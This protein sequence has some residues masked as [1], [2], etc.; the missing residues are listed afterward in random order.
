MPWECK[1][2]SAAAINDDVSACPECGVSKAS[3]T[4]IPDQTRQLT[5]TRRR[6]VQ[7][8]RSEDPGEPLEPE[9][10]YEGLALA[11]AESAP[12]IPKQKAQE[13]HEA[14]QRPAPGQLLFVRLFPREHT[15]HTVK[16]TVLYDMAEPV[17]VELPREEEAILR[18]DGS[19]DVPLLCVYGPDALPE[20]VSFA[21]IEIVDVS[22]ETPT[23]HASTL[24]VAALAKKRSDLPLSGLKTVLRFKCARLNF[25]TD[26]AIVRPVGLA[27]L[28]GVLKQVQADPERKLLIAGHTDTEASDAYNQALS[29]A[30]AKNVLD[31]LTGDAEAWVEDASR[32]NNSLN[33]DVRETLQWAARYWNFDCDPGTPH[34]GSLDGAAR[35][36][37]EQFK[38]AFNERFSQDHLSGGDLSGEPDQQFWRRVLNLYG[39]ALIDNLELEDGA[40]LQTLCDTIQWADESHGSIGCGEEQL[41]VET[42]D[43]VDEEANRR[44]DFLFFHPDEVPEPVGEDGRYLAAV[45]DTARFTIE[46]LPCPDPDIFGRVPPNVVF[47]IDVSGSMRP[48]GASQGRPAQ[49][50]RIGFAKRKL[51]QVIEDLREGDHF[52]VIAYSTETQMLWES[53]GA[54][55]LKVASEANRGEA[56]AWANALSASGITRTHEALELAFRASGFGAGAEKGIKFLSDGRPTPRSAPDPGAG[57]KRWYA[58][59]GARIQ[60]LVSEEEDAIASEVG[61]ASAGWVFD[62]IGFFAAQDEGGP[63]VDFMRR[64]AENNNGS[65]TPVGVPARPRD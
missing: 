22:E 52:T 62:T 45:Y 43:E 56:I 23:G 29:D 13:L 4:L 11:K 49:A 34:N 35:A 21:G 10:T 38:T 41:L 59:N 40:A 1:S 37:I 42:Q 50:D 48:A 54:P 9:G 58:D 24:G 17:E 7:L 16:A 25:N 64:L 44:I 20:E 60:A 28:R 63:L 15:D 19:F 61:A 51:A 39:H 65:F 47:V 8:L 36:Q 30:R 5:V 57:L 33:L 53:A 12:A 27:V 3:W 55:R 46:D 31:L 2:C 6:K 14:G 18:E 32:A 26:S